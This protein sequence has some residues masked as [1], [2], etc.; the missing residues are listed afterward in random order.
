MSLPVAA[1]AG[2]CRPGSR[3]GDR[4][5]AVPL[6]LEGPARRSSRGSSPRPREHRHDV[7]RHRLA[8][9]VGGRVHA[10][11]H[12][13]LL[14]RAGVEQRVAAAQPLAVE[15]D[16]RPCRGSHFSHV[17]GAAVPDRH[18]AGAVAALRGSR[19]R[20]RG[21][22]AGGPRRGPPC[23]SRLGSSGI[24]LGTAHEASTPSR[25][26]RRSQCSRRAWCSWTTKRAVAPW[27]SSLRLGRPG[28]RLGRRRKVAF[29]PVLAKASGSRRLSHA[30]AI[31]AHTHIVGTSTA[32][33][34]P[35]HRYVDRSIS[36]I[37]MAYGS[38]ASSGDA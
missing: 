7:L 3:V 12:P 23:G 17:V 9:R 36:G 19:P 21:T 24:P 15:D 35:E 18:L 11:D 27:A 28:R 38:G 37:I 34:A 13:V 10:V 16:D 25:S 30:H 32:T 20:S 31:R 4:A 29:A 33:G 22:R 2:A 6:D 1:L 14:A 26:R 8:R 5:H